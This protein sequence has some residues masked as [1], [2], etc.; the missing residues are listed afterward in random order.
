MDRDQVIAAWGKPYKINETIESWGKHEQ[1]VMHEDIGSDYIY[2]ENGILTS[3]G[4]LALLRDV[5]S[6]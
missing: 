1:W 4:Y 3:R 5:V 6:N 2:F